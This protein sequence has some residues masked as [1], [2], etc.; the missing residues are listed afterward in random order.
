MEVTSQYRD[1]D[2]LLGESLTKGEA[3]R[4]QRNRRRVLVVL[5]TLVAATSVIAIPVVSGDSRHPSEQASANVKLQA[6]RQVS[7]QDLGI[8]AVQQPSQQPVAGPVTS[9]PPSIGS[10]LAGTYASWMPVLRSGLRVFSQEVGG[11]NQV[12]V[13]SLGNSQSH[14]VPISAA[15]GTSQNINVSSL[16]GTVIDASGAIWNIALASFPSSDGGNLTMIGPCAYGPPTSTPQGT[17]ESIG[18]CKEVEIEFGSVISPT[19]ATFAEW[20]TLVTQGQLILTSP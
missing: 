4:C 8:Q 18:T 12:S 1:A 16:S 15:D 11:G 9:P 14:S 10:D 6:G 17:S 3:L 7:Y 19:A 13:A 2:I 5:A 20:T